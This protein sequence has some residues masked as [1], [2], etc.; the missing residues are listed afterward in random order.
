MSL[1]KK[2]AILAASGVAAS[3]MYRKGIDYT[4]SKFYK[5]LSRNK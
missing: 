2:I 1:T 3:I 5:G 4:I